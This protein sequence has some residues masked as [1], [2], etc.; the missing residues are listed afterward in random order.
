MSAPIPPAIVNLTRRERHATDGPRIRLIPIAEAAASERSSRLALPRPDG[1]PFH[2]TARI[3]RLISTIVERTPEFAHIHPERVLVSVALSRKPGPWGV[4]ARLTPLRFP[5][6]SEETVRGRHRYRVQRFEVDGRPMHYLLSLFT[7]RFLEQSFGQKLVTL[8]HELHHIHPEFNG[9]LRSFGTRGWH[10]GSPREYDRA[11]A[12]LARRFL[13]TRPD[14]LLVDHLRLRPAELV[15]L[16]GGVIGLFVP[17]PRLIPV[18]HRGA[19]RSVRKP[20]D[21][22]R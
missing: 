5:D 12:G 19:A 11:M 3:E 7:P 20:D 15:G 1:E 2:L 21:A 17:A 18:L 10:D 6:G 22:S 9:H 14:P 16:Y 4:Q 13:E 8:F